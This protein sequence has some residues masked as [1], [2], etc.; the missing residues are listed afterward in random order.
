VR[1]WVVLSHVD[2]L[3]VP[4]ELLRRNALGEALPY[5][6]C[7]SQPEVRGHFG[8][9]LREVLTASETDDIVL[10]AVGPLGI[11]HASQH[12]KTGAASLAPAMR[13]AL[14]FCFCSGCLD[15]LAAH[16]VDGE[17][18]RSELRRDILADALPSLTAALA[19]RRVSAHLASIANAASAHAV[20]AAVAAGASS[21]W[22]HATAEQ[23]AGG[24]AVSIGHTIHP[25]IV[26]AASSA[27]LGFIASCWG[28]A[29]ASEQRIEGLHRSAAGHEIG[30][31]VTV[32]GGE[33][34]DGADSLAARW[35]RL[36][37]AGS[38]ELH[39]YHAGLAQ[40]PA[41]DV[42][43]QALALLSQ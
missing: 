39:L 5:A 7:P 34:A 36:A 30:S 23:T 25:S 17:R 3:D 40:Q 10:E 26:S 29:A 2:G 33:H 21:V 38:K 8:T 24:P 41:F 35:R 32:L 4:S 22:I 9:L 15:S 27:S 1:A 18:L 11:D 6:A 16:G 43:R 12:D 19:D 28:P 31:Y 14:S 37:E 20:S 42:A 13:A